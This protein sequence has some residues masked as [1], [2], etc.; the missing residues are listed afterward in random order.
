MTRHEKTL[1]AAEYKEPENHSQRGQRKNSKRHYSN[2]SGSLIKPPPSGDKE[3]THNIGDSQTIEISVRGDLVAGSFHGLSPTGDAV[4]ATRGPLNNFNPQTAVSPFYSGFDIDITPQQQ[5]SLLDTSL[6]VLGSIPPSNNHGTTVDQTQAEEQS[7]PSPPRSSKDTDDQLQSFPMPPDLE[8]PGFF[9][10]LDDSLFAQVLFPLELMDFEISPQSFEHDGAVSSTNLDAPL[11]TGENMQQ[12][13]ISTDFSSALD[14]NTGQ[15]IP[16]PTSGRK[17]RKAKRAAIDDAIKAILLDDLRN[18]YRVADEQLRKLPSARVLDNFLWKFFQCFQRHLPI[19]HVPTFSPAT[20]AGPLLLALCSIGAL[21]SLNRKHGSLLRLIASAA[22]SSVR[23]GKYRGQQAPLEPIWQ[24]QCNLLITFGAIFGG[25]L[26]DATDGLSELG[27]AIR[28]YALRR[29]MLSTQ[30][31]A[32][33]VSTWE[34]W[35][36]YESAKRLLCGIYIASSL[37]SATYDISP[38]FSGSRDLNFEIPIEESIWEAE[39]REEWQQLMNIQQLEKPA[40]INAVLNQIVFGKETRYSTQTFANIGAFAATVVLHGVNVHMYYLAQSMSSLMVVNVE[41]N[42]GSAMRLSHH[43][44]TEVALSRCRE[45]LKAWQLAHDDSQQNRHEESLIFNCQ[46]LLRLSYVRVF[47]GIQQFNRTTLLYEDTAAILMAAN[48]YVTAPQ[49]R[50]AFLTKAVEQVMFCFT[51]PIRAGHMTT[52]K[53]AAFT[54]SIEHAVASW[55]CN[56]FLSKWVHTVEIQE[57]DVPLSQEEK[58]LLETLKEALQDADSPYDDQISLA[59]QVTRTWAL[60]M[61]DVWVWEITL[62]MG[63]VLRQVADVYDQS[64]QQHR[65]CNPP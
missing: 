52:R 43:T 45:F 39:T 59:A 64:W 26:G 62:R 53:T 60:F 40:T 25:S 3:T 30:S 65:I 58:A 1:H 4:S 57:R 31:L 2:S 33:N 44:Q 17:G 14:Q 16:P 46:S 48:S 36:N 7:M 8:N 27:L 47:S 18:N 12:D 23:P 5:T 28:P 50:N 54:W 21:Y 38:G 42:L 35:I 34:D 55:E 51:V 63:S 20:T 49:S 37:N 32:E 22:I 61:D 13:R 6:P 9:T 11:S 29:G 56:L 24:T 15:A 19:F 10:M 41:P